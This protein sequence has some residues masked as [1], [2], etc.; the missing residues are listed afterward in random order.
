MQAI[1]CW[2]HFDGTSTTPTAKD[3]NKPTNVEKKEIEAWEH[4]DIATQYLLSQRLPNTIAVCLYAHKTAKAHWDRLTTEFT[5]QSVYAQNDLEQA[6]FNMQCTKGTDVQTFLTSL[7]YKQ[8][9]LATAG[10]RITQREYQ[11]TVLKSLPDELTQFASQTLTSTRHIGH[12]L[13][14]DTLINS[15][16]EESECLKNQRTCSQ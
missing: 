2:S 10:V 3:T 14:T 5:V 16:I 6:F 8:E 11:R 7:R 1:Q 15:V 9:E 13:D 12:P 4:D